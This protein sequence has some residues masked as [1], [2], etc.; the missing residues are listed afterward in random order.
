MKQRIA[1][2]LAAAAM[3]LVAFVPVARSASPVCARLCANA[4]TLD[5]EA[6]TDAEEALED[7]LDEYKEEELRLR[8][9]R[10]SDMASI[11]KAEMEESLGPLQ[12]RPRREE[13]HAELKQRLVIPASLRI[14]QDGQE[15]RIDEGRGGP[16]RFD[17]EEPYSRVDSF[18][19]AR[20]SARLSGNS[21]TVAEK[22]RR[23]R[24]NTEAYAVDA[25]S[26]MLVVTR[27]LTRQSMP[28]LVVRSV[29]R[30]AP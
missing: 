24:S 3:G 9:P 18:G 27:T 21:F 4:W 22:Y 11:E 15:F 10:G 28:H 8:G 1:P 19:T 25:K 29:Y 14:S 16:R 5:A 12:R 17:L 2:W 30:P 23:G 20:I 7:A 13:L 26:G 6:S